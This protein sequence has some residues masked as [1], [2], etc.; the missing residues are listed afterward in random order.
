LIHY[1][2]N[3]PFQPDQHNHTSLNAE[4]LHHGI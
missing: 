2:S 3:G 4:G 1:Q